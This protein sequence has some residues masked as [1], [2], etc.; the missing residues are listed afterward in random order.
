MQSLLII[1]LALKLLRLTIESILAAINKNHYQN[2]IKQ[3]QTCELLGIPHEDFAKT[4]AYTNDKYRFGQVTGWLNFA[5]F[6]AFLILGGFGWIESFALTMASHLSESQILVGLIFYAVLGGLSFIVSIPFD[7]YGTFVIEERH[8][9]NRQTVAGFWLDAFKGL[10]VGAIM[11]GLFLSLILLIMGAAGENWWIWAWAATSIFSLITAWAYPTFLAPLFNK[12]TPLTEGPLRESIEAFANKIGFGTSGIFLMDASRRSSHGNAYFTG[13][14]GKKRIVLFDNLVETMSNDEVV[15]VLAHELG[16]FKLN[17]VRWSL[18]RGV[19]IMGALFY[20]LGVCL[21][22]V[23]F[24]HAFHFSGVS[25]YAA[26]TVFSLW[27]GVID[28]YWTPIMSWLS[29]RNEFQADA[30]AK[31]HLSNFRDL[32]TALLKLRQKN[33]AMPISHPIFSSVYHS[34]PPI[35]ERLQAMGYQSTVD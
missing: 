3:K 16:H 7:L 6:S 4:L 32:C 18:V 27:L 11:G 25:N 10:A 13:V 8:G 31:Q 35:A 28:F 22:L 1:F 2:P 14:F 26:L 29:R 33:H 19:M 5:A 23:D 24:Y 12:F 15:A 34:H 17:H 20:A 21:P 30:F 9:F